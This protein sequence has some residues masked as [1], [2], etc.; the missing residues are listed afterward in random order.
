MA[1]IKFCHVDDF[2]PVCCAS[3][4]KRCRHPFQSALPLVAVWADDAKTEEAAIKKTMQLDL[5]FMMMAKKSKK[6]AAKRAAFLLC[7][8]QQII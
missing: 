6:N 8:F 2:T 3:G 5:F 4:C 7:E 1:G